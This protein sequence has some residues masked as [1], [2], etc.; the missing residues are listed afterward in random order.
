M[1][2]INIIKK[3]WSAFLPAAA[4][5]LTLVLLTAS[6]TFAGSATWKASPATDDWNTAA[7]WTPRT[8]PN[9]PAD[10]ATFAS[11]HQTGVFI[12]LDTEVNGIVFKPRASAFT[13]ASEPTLTPAVTISGVGVTNNSGILQ[14]FVINSGG[15][16][17]FFLNSATAGSLTAFTSAGTI[18]FGGT[19]TAGNA[20][21]TNNNL[22]KFANTSTA[23]DATLYQ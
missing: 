19:S 23:G 21:F 7:N 1:Q 15:A 3:H 20:A 16:Q 18:S 11:S 6:S 10:T 8:V 2:S 5:I 13:I 17:I 4:A 14:N 12:T 9:G 22:L